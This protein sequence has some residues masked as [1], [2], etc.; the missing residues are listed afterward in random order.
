MA[1]LILSIVFLYGLMQK[2]GRD[3]ETCTKST[4]I[5]IIMVMVMLYLSSSKTVDADKY[6]CHA[7]QRQHLHQGATASFV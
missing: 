4:G 3:E 5:F 7:E 6:I 2:K 1:F